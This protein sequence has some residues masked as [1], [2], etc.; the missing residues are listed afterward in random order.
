M[1]DSERTDDKR[2]IDDELTDSGVAIL[3]N[4]DL[5]LVG[6][7]EAQLEFPD[8]KQRHH[9]QTELRWNS[10]CDAIVRDFESVSL[11]S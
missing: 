7:V 4:I 1:S 9:R 3:G 10:A 11:Q 5:E 2:T 6:T 8:V